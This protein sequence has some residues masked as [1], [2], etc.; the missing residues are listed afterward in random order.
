[1]FNIKPL[2]I[3]FVKTNLNTIL[4]KY[5][6]PLIYYYIYYYV[7]IKIKIFYCTIDLII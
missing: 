4:N 7:N 1:M 6:K 2:K 3:N 5:E